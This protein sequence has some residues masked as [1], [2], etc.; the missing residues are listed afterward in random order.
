MFEANKKVKILFQLTDEDA[1]ILA[2]KKIGRKLSAEELEKVK[3]G[4]EFGLEYWEE[5]I[6]TAIEEIVSDK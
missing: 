3:T 2:M 4:L 1:Q 6:I 5:V